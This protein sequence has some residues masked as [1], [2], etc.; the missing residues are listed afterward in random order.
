MPSA[1]TPDATSRH[2]LPKTTTLPL[3]P[4]KVH[5]WFASPVQVERM[6]AA[7][8]AFE[9]AVRHFSGQSEQ[10]KSKGDERGLYGY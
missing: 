7:P 1:L 3:L 4:V 10:S 6:T 2:L 5:F 9:D 8:S